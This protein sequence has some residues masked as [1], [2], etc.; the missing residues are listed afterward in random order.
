MSAQKALCLLH[1]FELPHAPLPD[2][3]RFVRQLRSIV[4]ILGSVV[5]RFWNQLSMSHPIAPQ[6]IRD[7]L[8]WL[9][10]V[11]MQETLKENFSRPFRRG[12]SS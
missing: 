3:R 10:F 2:S 11:F 1:R 5:N 12:D 4:R 8:A 9:A 7:N 6:F